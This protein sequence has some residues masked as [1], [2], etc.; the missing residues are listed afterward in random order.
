MGLPHDSDLGWGLE[1]V[2]PSSDWTPGEEPCTP[3]YLGDPKGVIP[4]GGQQ[5]RA[6][7]LVHPHVSA[8]NLRKYLNN[9]DF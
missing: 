8:V 3:G 4:P 2:S 7:P 5:M 1:L 9:V 6:S